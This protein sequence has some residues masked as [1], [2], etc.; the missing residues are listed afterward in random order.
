MRF[1][2]FVLMRTGGIAII[3]V[4]EV[5]NRP[6]SLTLISKNYT[7]NNERILKEAIEWRRSMSDILG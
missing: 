7:I 4:G 2:C 6:V 1:R 3:I 5:A